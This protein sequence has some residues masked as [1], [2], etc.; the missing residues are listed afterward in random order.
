MH[1]RFPL[2]LLIPG[3]T[4]PLSLTLNFGLLRILQM[5]LIQNPQWE[6]KVAEKLLR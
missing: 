5:T 1:K 3:L 6:L 2:T 4:L